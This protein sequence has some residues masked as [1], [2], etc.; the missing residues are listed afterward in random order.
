MNIE[1]Q[2]ICYSTQA[3]AAYCYMKDLGNQ[4]SYKKRKL[5]TVFKWNSEDLDRWL[6]YLKDYQIKKV[7]LKNKLSNT[8]E[9]QRSSLPIQKNFGFSK[10]NSR[11]NTSSH[12]K[13]GCDVT[14]DTAAIE[15]RPK[16][17]WINKNKNLVSTRNSTNTKC[18]YKNKTL[19]H[20]KS[21][22]YNTRSGSK[23]IW[24]NR[25]SQRKSDVHLSDRM[26]NI[27]KPLQGKNTLTHKV[28]NRTCDS[29]SMKKY[30]SKTES[31]KKEKEGSLVMKE[32]K[33]K[34][35]SRNSAI[36]KTYSSN[37]AREYHSDKVVPKVNLQLHQ[38]NK[39]SQ[40]DTKASKE[41]V[42]KR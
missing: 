18:P 19:D 42:P 26:A 41:E 11:P 3:L 2:N 37:S 8:K 31:T 6:R 29:Q 38:A 33:S 24:S 36:K 30:L 20:S 12:S 25:F 13:T 23:N 17:Y 27:K 7:P 34:E 9:H 16:K 4:D 28:Y 40:F 21:D 22:L 10:S 1:L 32:A 15:K 35:V 14:F 39:R 5:M